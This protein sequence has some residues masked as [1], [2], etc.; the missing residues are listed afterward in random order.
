MWWYLYN[1]FDEMSF[2]NW[3]ILD[4]INYLLHLYKLSSEIYLE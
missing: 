4:E 3:Q 2:G 1:V